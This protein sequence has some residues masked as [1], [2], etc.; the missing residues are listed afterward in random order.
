M[1]ERLIENPTLGKFILERLKTNA[2]DSFEIPLSKAIENQTG[3]LT[4]KF[5]HLEKTTIGKKLGIHKK[6]DLKDLPYTDYAFYEPFYENPTQDAFIYPLEEYATLKTSGTTGRNKTIL[7]PRRAMQKALRET[8]LPVV[9]ALFH[10]DKKIT[11]QYGDTFYLNMGP[12]PYISGSMFNM[13]SKNKR[14]P[15][16][17]L[18][19][20]INITYKEKVDYFILNHRK[21]DAA[22]IMASTLI[23]Q[24]MPKLKEP[25]NLKG[26]IVMDDLI[27]KTHKDDIAKFTG[28]SPKTCFSSTETISPTIPSVQH[29]MGFIFDPRRGI[30][31]FT[32]CENEQIDKTIGLEQVEVGK[33]YRLIYTDLIGEITRY[34]TANAFKCIAKGDNIINTDYPVFEYNSRL[35][36]TISIMNFTRMGEAELFE[37]FHIL[38]LNF[39]DFT[40]KLNMEQ[41]REYLYIYAEVIDQNQN[42]ITEENI[43]RY[44]Y[45]KNPDYK[46]LSDSF[47]Y[48]PIRL[49]FL[50]QGTFVNYLE[51]RKG[52]FPKICRIGISD[53]ELEQLCSSAE[54]NTNIG[55]KT[56]T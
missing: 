46:L 2:F 9:F 13:G 1:L 42:R 20:N 10:D 27:A 6:T 26:I 23:T 55:S 38:G 36:S 16:L 30:F 3:A 44:F 17:K 52:A 56:H 25:I 37:A 24:I 4:H 53:Y 5:E 34:D 8:A 21:I 33:V 41:G 22:W 19:P 45:A 7:V 49:R 32:T 11:L 43:H 47:T 48:R 29:S 35:D 31:E 15:F 18:V 54:N 14:A 50:P 12:A 40:T 39:V 51:N 28:T